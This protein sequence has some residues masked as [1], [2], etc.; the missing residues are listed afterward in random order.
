M[1][2]VKNVQLSDCWHFLKRNLQ[3]LHL[4]VKKQQ[5]ILLILLNSFQHKVNYYS[6]KTIGSRRK[7]EVESGVSVRWRESGVRVRKE[8]LRW[9]GHGQAA[10]RQA[11]AAAGGGQPR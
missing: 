4:I 3:Q 5:H 6:S 8:R 7:V 10:R 11:G 9:R 2:F 1:L